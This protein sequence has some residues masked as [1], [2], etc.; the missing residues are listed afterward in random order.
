[1]H[2]ADDVHHLFED[3]AADLA[4][5]VG[6]GE[7]SPMALVTARW[8]GASLLLGL[9]AHRHP[10]RATLPPDPTMATPIIVSA[11]PAA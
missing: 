11:T 6:A 8:L 1:M 10:R 7:I 3:R 4:G 9:F 2:E 5:A